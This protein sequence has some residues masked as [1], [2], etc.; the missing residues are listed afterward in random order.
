MYP[1]EQV[2]HGADNATQFDRHRPADRRQIVC[3]PLANGIAQLL[4]RL[5]SAGDGKPDD[6]AGGRGQEQQPDDGGTH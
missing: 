3:R 2:V 4:Q 6:D 5:Q 1:F